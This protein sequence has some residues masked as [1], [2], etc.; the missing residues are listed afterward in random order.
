MNGIRTKEL[1]NKVTA[2]SRASKTILDFKIG[3]ETT[4]KKAKVKT[5]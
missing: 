5:L 2:R 4:T 1:D 3:L